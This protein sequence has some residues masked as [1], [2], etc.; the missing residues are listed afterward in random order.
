MAK[1]VKGYLKYMMYMCFIQAS[2][3]CYN[4]DNK[5]D[6]IVKS[7]A[8]PKNHASFYVFFGL[9]GRETKQ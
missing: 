5:N 1:K 9:P 8:S 6:H 4:C 2:E 3:V 7:L